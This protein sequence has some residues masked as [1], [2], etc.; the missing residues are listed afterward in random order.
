[1]KPAT[2][3]RLP[4]WTL[5]SE[6]SGAFL[7]LHR[8]LNGRRSFTLC[9]LTYSD[10]VYRDKVAGFLEGRLSAHVRVS[11]DPT[12]R[13]GTEALFDSLSADPR[14]SP[15]Q[16][17]GLE[18]WPEG[19]DDLLGRLNRRRETLAERCPRPLLFWVLSSHLEKVATRAADLWAWRSGV[20]DF[21][22]PSRAVR[23]DLVQH[24]LDSPPV[25]G[26]ERQ[27]RIEK[28]QRYLATRSSL[29]PTDVDLLLDM[30]D[31]LMWLGN[32]TEA[33]TAY[34]RA[35]E[36]LA[37]LD[38]GKRYAIARGKIADIL[39]ERGQ[40]D[41]ALRIRTEEQLPVFEKLGDVH[42]RAITQGK[43]ADILQIRGQLDE[44]LRI[45]TEEQL[46]VFEKLG[47]TR[48]HAITK[49]EIADILK[50]RGQLDE[51]FKIRT[52]EV[53][54]VLEKLGDVYSRIITKDRIADIHHTRGQLDEALR[55]RTEEVLP[56]LEKLGDTRSRA[57]TK[58]KIADILRAR[59]QLDEALRIRTEEVLPVFEKL[60]DARSCAIIRAKIAD[61]LQAQGQ[62]DEALRIRTEEVLP[63]FEK[64]GDARS[65]AIT[66][67]RI[68]DILQ[69]HEQVD[70]ALRIYE[71]HVLPNVEAL[72]LSTEMDRVRARIEELRTKLG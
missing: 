27:V 59:G 22:L 30:G 12:A 71:Q 38:D 72:N 45:R 53:L 69:A 7:R 31:L 37:T 64:L 34:S 14:S 18:S 10:S 58:G 16:I 28:I 5:R 43:I 21:T 20:Y 60:G 36:A 32:T 40:L 51:A 52:E 62:L 15:A 70:E 65:C 67:A 55:I 6:H 42:S 41:E 54:P 48:L 19:L 47:D 3:S 56:V 9:F 68:A 39:E 11:I 1:M 50:E 35:Q 4:P 61:I 66:R 25:Y 2:D 49:G 63:V 46:P 26:P 13:I 8:L 23:T 57:I 24:H 17:T 44:A 33:A 29:R